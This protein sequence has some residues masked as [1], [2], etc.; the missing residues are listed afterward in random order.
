[1]RHH[2]T[3]QYSGALPVAKVIISITRKSITIATPSVQSTIVAALVPI[4]IIS[5][6]IGLKANAI[7]RYT[8]P[9][10]SSVVI[11]LV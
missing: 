11:M 4:F 9:P 6:I 2:A 10:Y 7:K 1:M 8:P 5:F 3:D